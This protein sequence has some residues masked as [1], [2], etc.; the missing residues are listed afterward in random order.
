MHHNRLEMGLNC[1]VRQISHEDFNQVKDLPPDDW[2]FNYT[3]FLLTHLQERYFYSIVSTIGSEIT[4]TGNAFNFGKTGWLANIIVKPAYRRQGIGL[5]ITQHLVLY[6]RKKGCNTLFLLAT[7]SGKNVYQKAGFK[8]VM[9]YRYF[10]SEYDKS[11]ARPE[12]I[13]KIK[14]SDLDGIINMDAQATAED[15]SPL[16]CR[17]YK[18]GWVYAAGSSISGFYIPD[19]GRGAVIAVNKEAGLNLLELKHS[20]QLTRSAVPETNHDAV[21]FFEEMGFKENSPCSRMVL[22]SQIAWNPQNIYSYAHG[23]CG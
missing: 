22:G 14:A 19:F 15:R 23:Y 7:E 20:A 10:T 6:L 5:F 9:K 12:K 11:F 21:R 13:R 4:G 2:N 16:I 17:F 3:D 1:S 18:S 8:R